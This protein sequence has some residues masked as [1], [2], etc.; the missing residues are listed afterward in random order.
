[1]AIQLTVGSNTFTIPTDRQ[2]PGWGESLSDWCIAVTDA[3]S[4][5]V[6]PTDITRTETILN[7]NV[8]TPTDITFLSF[9]GASVRA[10]NVTY[11]IVRSSSTTTSG[12][13]ESGTIHL[14]Y[15]PNATS[16]NKWSFTQQ[17]LG[18][19][20]VTISITD[21]GQMQ[22]TTNDIGSTSYVGKIVF[23]AKTLS[24]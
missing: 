23:S 15:D 21:A 22:Y 8:S 6:G 2:S 7:N 10:A 12:Y 5:V 13:T 19:S 20:G 4:T 16:G 24:T 14:N 11:L 1:M 17:I 9:D 18:Y 3:L